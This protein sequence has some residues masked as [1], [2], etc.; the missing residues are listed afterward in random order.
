MAPNIAPHQSFMRVSFG[1]NRLTHL[2]FQQPSSG[3][4][5]L[6]V[7]GDTMTRSER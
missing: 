3:S 2:L 1:E 6:G 7:T 5:G 4:K